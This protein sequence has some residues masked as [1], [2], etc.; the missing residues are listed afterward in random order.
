M[1]DVTG[2]I[3]PSSLCR[4]ANF[5]SYLHGFHMFIGFFLFISFKNSASITSAI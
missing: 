5:Y 4:K 2:G 3:V 1:Q